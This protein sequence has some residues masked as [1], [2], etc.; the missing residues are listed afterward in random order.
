MKS[1]RV[2]RQADLGRHVVEERSLPRCDLLLTPDAGAA[3]APVPGVVS[4][5][6]DHAVVPGVLL[7]GGLVGVL[8]VDELLGERLLGAPSQGRERGRVDPVGI[9]VL[10]DPPPPLGRLAGLVALLDPAPLLLVFLDPS[11][12]AL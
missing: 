10:E 3:P 7:V 6:T 4:D 1:R 9:G 12:P 2:L 5:L 8:E 11:V